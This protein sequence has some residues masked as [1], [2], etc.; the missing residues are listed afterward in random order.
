[1]ANHSQVLYI[2]IIILLAIKSLPFAYY[3]MA[4]QIFINLIGCMQCQANCMNALLG[5]L[6]FECLKHT[7]ADLYNF[8]VF[9]LNYTIIVV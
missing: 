2:R 7:L 4:H 5:H 6:F 9:F 3:L 8:I 1:M